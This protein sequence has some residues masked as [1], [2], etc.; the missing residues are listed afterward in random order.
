MGRADVSKRLDRAAF[1][2]PIWLFGILGAVFILKL[3]ILLELRD[4]PLLQPDS[5]LD[6]TAYVDLAR[7]VVAGDWALGPGLYFVSPLYIYVLAIVLKVSGSFTVLRVGQ[8]LLGTAT[9]ACV[10]AMAREWF[11]ET[12]ARI[13]AVLAAL[14]G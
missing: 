1:T 6:T 10:Y 12:A 14:T 2:P 3:T 11:G 8:I 13:A 5:G 9:V 4:H 7:R